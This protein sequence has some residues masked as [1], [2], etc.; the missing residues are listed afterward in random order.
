M[1]VKLEDRK[2]SV[3]L[4]VCAAVVLLT[5]MVATVAFERG[6]ASAAQ[7]DQYV[8]RL[9]DGPRVISTQVVKVR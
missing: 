8:V 1:S 9:T 2:A 6:R 4:A 3:A 7:P 5:M